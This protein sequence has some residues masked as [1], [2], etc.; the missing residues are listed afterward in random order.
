MVGGVPGRLDSIPKLHRAVLDHLTAKGK[1]STTQI[2]TALEHPTTSTRRALEDL[3]AHHVVMRTA[4]GSGKPDLWR[5]AG[6]ALTPLTSIDTTLPDIS[7]LAPE[8][9]NQARN[10][11]ERC[12]PPLNSTTTCGAPPQVDTPIDRPHP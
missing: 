11:R 10:A 6:Q 7:G 9:L 1:Q 4:G 12:E 5:L 8:P 3:T 2:A